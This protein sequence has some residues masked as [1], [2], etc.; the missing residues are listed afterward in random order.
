MDFAVGL[1]LAFGLLFFWGVWI[2][3]YWLPMAKEHQRLFKE[4]AERERRA[5]DERNAADRPGSISDGDGPTP[6]P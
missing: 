4:Q 1:F 6:S 2:F 5:E 3:G